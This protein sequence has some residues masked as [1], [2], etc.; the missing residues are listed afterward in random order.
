MAAFC[1][2]LATSSMAAEPFSPQ[3]KMKAEKIMQKAREYYQ[4]SKSF[5]IKFKSKVFWAS[6]EEWNNSG[7]KL[8]LGQQQKFHLFLPDVEMVSDGVNLWKYSV[9]NKQVTLDHAEDSKAAGASARILFSFLQCEP[10][11]LKIVK[12]KGA[13]YIHLGLKPTKSLKNYET[14]EVFLNKK[15]HSPHKIKT[16]DGGG[17]ISIYTVTKLI[18]NK[19][20]KDKHFKFTVPK[21]VEL[22]DLRD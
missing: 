7:G 2:L 5:S 19:K 20:F 21:K 15:D 11:F 16:T 1:F 22:V 18:R 3:D 6:S 10:L 13:V 8:W 4:S 12:E 9:S 17:N 14:V